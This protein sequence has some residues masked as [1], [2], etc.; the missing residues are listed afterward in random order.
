MAKLGQIVTQPNGSKKILTS[1]GWVDH[2]AE[3]ESA[4]AMG[5]LGAVG[6]SVLESA[7]LG[8]HEVPQEYREV[9]PVA[10]KSALAAELATGVGVLG[11]AGVRAAAG[12]VRSRM[13]DRVADKVAEANRKSDLR[14]R[15][16]DALGSSTAAGQMMKRIEGAV[17]VIPGLN[18]PLLMQRAMNQRAINMKTAK[19]MGLDEDAVMDARL[20]ISG[21]LIG[22]ALKNYKKGFDEV[23]QN[24]NTANIPAEDLMPVLDTAVQGGMLAPKLARAISKKTRPTGQQIM[25]ARSSL[26]KMLDSQEPAMREV[27]A[28]L[29]DNIDEIIEEALTGEQKDAFKLLRA[30]YRVWANVRKGRALSPDGQV[31]VKTLDSAFK[32]RSGYGDRYLAEE[33]IDGLPDEVNDL[34][35]EVRRGAG[36]DVG[37]PSSGT[38]ERSVITNAITGN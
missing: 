27:A 22:K 15:P 13:A 6:Q 21:P 9:S 12:G 10:T 28:D 31:N 26:V 38:A 7:T 11:R 1:S 25:D 29:I 20:G 36:L 34:L 19:A 32:S 16:S 35:Q 30:Q 18:A 14:G 23:Q 4:A 3:L 17:E 24:L 37:I 5:V 8:L 33:G 2:T